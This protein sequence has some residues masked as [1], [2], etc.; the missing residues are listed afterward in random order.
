M[1]FVRK[2][3][4]AVRPY[5]Y[6]TD[7]LRRERHLYAGRAGRA[8]DAILDHWATGSVAFPGFLA[9]DGTH[10]KVTFFARGGAADLEGT[11]AETCRR[12][13]LAAA[14]VAI[15]L[16]GADGAERCPVTPRERECL[17]LVAQG[18]RI[19]SIADRLGLAEVTV[20]LHLAHA[21]AKLDARTTAQAVA[22]AV[23]LG[24]IHP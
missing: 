15:R 9:P 2:A 21:R 6:H 5:A 19:D 3:H 14:A 1:R 22:T 4:W 11:F 13:H 24:A 12:L 23:M 10:W 18:L 8:M 16:A 7:T 17:L 20:G